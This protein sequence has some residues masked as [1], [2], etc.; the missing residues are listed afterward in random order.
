MVEVPE[1]VLITKDNLFVQVHANIYNLLNNRSN[2]PDPADSTGERKFVY[3]REPNSESRNFA[4]YPYIVVPY[5]EFSQGNKTADGTKAFQ[6]DSFEI[7]VMTQDK[8]SDSQGNQ[9]GARQLADIKTNLLKTLNNKTNAQTL[10]NNGL[11]NR[12]I[13]SATFD[14]GEEDGK[15]IF[16]TEFNLRFNN[17]LRTIA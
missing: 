8:T 15:Q 12:T 3:T 9:S 16:R 10:R 5:P 4:G 2:V 1:S 7:I 17:Q 14:W 6:D 11:R 13:P